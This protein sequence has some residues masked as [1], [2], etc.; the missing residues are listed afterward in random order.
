MTRSERFRKDRAWLKTH[1]FCT[2]M[3]LQQTMDKEGIGIEDREKY[4]YIQNKVIITGEEDWAYISR[5][6]WADKC[7]PR[8]RRYIQTMQEWDELEL[9]LSY[10]AADDG[11]GYPMSYRVPQ[12]Q[13]DMG[14]CNV[15]FNRQRVRAPKPKNNPTDDVSQFALKNLMELDLRC[16]L[17]LPDSPERRSRI[18]AHCEHVAFKDFALTYGRECRRLFHRC[19]MMPSEGRCN[20]VHPFGLVEYDV[21]SCHPVLLLPYFSDPAEHRRYSKMLE[22]DIYGT[23]GQE[24]GVPDRDVVKKDFLRVVNAGWKSP[25]WLGTKGVFRFFQE[26][27][28]SFTKSTLSGR[29]DLALTLQ[30]AEADLMVQRLGMFCREKDLFWIPQHDGWITTTFHEVEISREAKR[31]IEEAVHFSPE[32][33]REN[34]FRV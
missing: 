19:V 10:W 13:W 6:Y 18:R 23:I 24:I 4:S 22:G 30:N 21:K 5:K 7:G 27:Y 12:T 26:R 8:Y 2:T 16:D 1:H 29:T 14:R 31:I 25:E 28:P 9:D 33:K 32:L 15:D 3:T 20:L 11:T 17:I 34:L